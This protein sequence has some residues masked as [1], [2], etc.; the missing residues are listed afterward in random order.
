MATHAPHQ[1]TPEWVEPYRGMFDDGWE[2]WRERAFERQLASGIAPPGTSLTERPSWVQPWDELDADARRLFAR[3]HEVYAGF[4]THTD[5]QI[6]R[7]IDH[8]EAIGELDNTVVILCSDN[9]ASA[10]GGHVG[11]GQ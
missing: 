10:E 2:R 1:V 7:V 11:V 9:G 5:A 3:M 4:V 6:G 8:L